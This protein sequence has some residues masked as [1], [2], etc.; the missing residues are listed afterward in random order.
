MYEWYIGY[1]RNPNRLD[2]FDVF[3]N[4]FLSLRHFSFSNSLFL[5][6]FQYLCN[7]NPKGA[8]RHFVCSIHLLNH[9]L[10]TKEKSEE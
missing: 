5:P 9:H 3:P 8:Q 2:S 4:N 1:V 6:N 7:R 10:G